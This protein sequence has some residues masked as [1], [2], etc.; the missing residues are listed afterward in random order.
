[1]KHHADAREELARDN[2]RQY[3]ARFFLKAERER[4]LKCGDE[5]TLPLFSLPLILEAEGLLSRDLQ[6]LQRC[7]RAIA[8][9]AME[10]AA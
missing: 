6:Y 3:S 9:A 4:G 1:M 2:A 7:E 5:N 10:W 8:A